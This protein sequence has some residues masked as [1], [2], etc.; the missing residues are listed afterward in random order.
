M[1]ILEQFR[2]IEKKIRIFA[3][4][5]KSKF[6]IGRVTKKP[7][8]HKVQSFRIKPTPEDNNKVF[9]FPYAKY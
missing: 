4:G 3:N 1:I 6:K 5:V 8:N 7:K 9:C 2:N